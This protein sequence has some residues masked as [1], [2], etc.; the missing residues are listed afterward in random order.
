MSTATSPLAADAVAGVTDAALRA[1][2][3][4]HWEFMMKWAPTWAT[5]LGD[6]RYDD[7]LAPRDARS[8][9]AMDAEHAAILAQLTALDESTTHS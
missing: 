2:L 5:T 3:A 4:E 8:I 7:R 9:A 6:H 1:V